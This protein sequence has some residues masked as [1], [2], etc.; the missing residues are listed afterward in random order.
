MTVYPNSYVE[1]CSGAALSSSA[2]I[3]SFDLNVKHLVGTA[4][5][6]K[7]FTATVSSPPA[8]CTPT[9]TYVLYYISPLTGETTTNPYSTYFT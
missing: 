4:L 7:S 8:S 3:A 1:A 5:T 9:Y 6:D 2:T